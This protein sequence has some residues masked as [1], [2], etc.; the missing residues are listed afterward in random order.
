MPGMSALI[1]TLPDILVHLERE[2]QRPDLLKVK[3]GGA[4][5]PI[6]TSEVS[7]R[8][9]GLS[10]GLAELG[11]GPGVKVALLSENRPEWIIADL[12]V[13]AG[14]GV[15]VPIYVQLPPAQI[16]H[17]L[18]DSE[19]EIILCSTPE[20]WL[21]VEAVRSRLPRLA[22]AVLFEGAA[23]GLLTLDEVTLRGEALGRA[24]PDR[25]GRA[26]RAVRPGDPAS[27]IYTSGTTGVPKG[28]VLSHGNLIAN[29]R[30]TDSVIH[31][32]EKDM[33]LSFLP[34]AHVLERM[35]TYAV[36]CKGTS[37]AYGGGVE[38]VA[39]DLLEARPTALVAVPRLFEKMYARIMDQVIAGS[40]LKRRIFYLAI[41]AGRRRARRRPAEMAR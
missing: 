17:L 40:A 6:P 5:R 23:P 31:Y 1:K 38:T 3:S 35:T 16:E 41:S 39:A 32:D 33:T 24:D 11:L 10:L 30:A 21:K 36:L 37:V 13:L 15:T 9:R 25:F 2:V 22:R 14:G 7:R 27:I 20:L 29:I 4:F 8:V 18:D 34:L 12:A 26:V 19:S 28:V